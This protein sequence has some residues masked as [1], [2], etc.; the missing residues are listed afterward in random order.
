MKYT[1][2]VEGR[3]YQIEVQGSRMLVDGQPLDVDVRRIAD[4][5]L[6]SLLVNSESA[7]VSV[8]EEGHY[9]YRVM[10]GGELYAVVVQPPGRA[11]AP[12]RG[13]PSIADNIIRAPMPGLVASVPVV[14][15]QEVKAGTVLVVLESMKM[16]NPLMAP[17]DGVV[18]Q[19][20]VHP[21]ESVERNQALIT[22]QFSNESELARSG[23]KGA[24]S[25]EPG[26]NDASL[27][28]TGSS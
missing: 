26:G 23:A 9:R 27:L 8:E 5:P 21:R 25:Q 6:Y 16:E 10:L 24:R 1:V 13:H 28:V 20:H 7:E 4:L 12:E 2:E 11:A 22:L 14:S 19:V 17:A 15:G 3:Q 18:T